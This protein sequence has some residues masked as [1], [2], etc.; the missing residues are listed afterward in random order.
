M[1]FQIIQTRDYQRLQIYEALLI[2]KDKPNIN[3]QINNFFNPLKLYGKLAG[4]N[5]I[6]T[7]RNFEITVQSNSEARSNNGDYRESSHLASAH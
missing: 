5:S 7:Q 4:N 3:R 2:L 1:Q 6:N